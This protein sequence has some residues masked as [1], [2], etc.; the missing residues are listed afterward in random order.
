M[1]TPQFE[2]VTSP[3]ESSFT[4]YQYQQEEFY[5]PWHFHPEYELTY[6]VSSQGMRYV[7]TNIEHFE[8]QDLVLLG[9]NLPHCWKNTEKHHTR[10]RS[11]IIQWEEDILGEGWLTKSEFLPIRRLC[12]QSIRGIKFDNLVAQKIRPKLDDLLVQSPF[13]KVIQLLQILHRLANTQAFKLLSGDEFAPNPSHEDNN[14]INTV[15]NYVKENYDKNITLA[16]AAS[17]TA[18]SEEAFCRFFTQKASKSFFT[19]V[20]D[21]KINLACQRLIRTPMQVTQIAYECGYNSLPFFYRQFKKFKGCTPT[22]YR[23]Q[24]QKVSYA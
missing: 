23:G 13:E 1:P 2:I 6:I 3:P 14:R 12:K 18:M 19:F 10:A 8:E 21:Y 16:E 7:G 20:N 11:I 17:L 5:T 4:V 22:E 15:Y 24:Y 9:P